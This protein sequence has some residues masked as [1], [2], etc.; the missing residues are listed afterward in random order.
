MSGYGTT[1][2]DFL[3]DSNDH[4]IVEV[5]GVPKKGKAEI[6]AM[7]SRVR[8]RHPNT[9]CYL[10]SRESKLPKWAFGQ[11]EVTCSSKGRK[12]LTMFGLLI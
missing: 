8:L 3:G 1:D 6:S 5:L 12:D 11:Q 4:W 2:D 10:M 7:T 9:G